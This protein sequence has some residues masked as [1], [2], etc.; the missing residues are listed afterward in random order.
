MPSFTS[1]QVNRSSPIADAL[2]ANEQATEEV[3]T[4][5]DELAV[6]HAVL[7]TKLSQDKHDAEFRKAIADTD[8]VAKH[9][10]EAAEKLDK[11]N[12]TLQREMGHS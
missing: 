8:K 2:E 5:A 12:E 6:V 1:P 4:A 10:D 9:L 11:A 7:D 3:Q